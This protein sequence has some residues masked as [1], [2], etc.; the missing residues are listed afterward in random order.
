MLYC[1]LVLIE[2]VCVA[3]LST[4]NHKSNV[5]KASLIELYPRLSAYCPGAYIRF[6]LDM[7]IEMLVQCVKID[8][9]KAVSMKTIGRLC[10]SMGVHM[11]YHVHVLLA[12]VQDALL[13]DDA[14]K[15]SDGSLKKQQHKKI[16]PEALSCV[17]DMVCGLGKPFQQQVLE[18]LDYMLQSGLT[19][20]LIEALAVIA[21]NMPAHKEFIHQKL[22]GEIM[23]VLSGVSYGPRSAQSAKHSGI[24]N[25]SPDATLQEGSMA[26]FW[27]YFSSFYASDGERKDNRDHS[28]NITRRNSWS[29]RSSDEMNSKAAVPKRK[30]FGPW[31]DPETTFAEDLPRMNIMPGGV[32]NKHHSPTTV[33]DNA[34]STT[35]NSST[36]LPKVS[37]V[38][39][40]I[41]GDINDEDSPSFFK[42][43][44]ELVLLAM[45]TLQ[46]LST[47]SSGV[48]LLVHHHILP[49]LCAREEAVREEAASTAAK[50][51]APMA[52]DR[53][54]S[55]RGPSAD[56]LHMVLTRLLEVCVSDSSAQ[57]RMKVLKS[58][59]DSFDKHLLQEQRI[60]SLF[61]L[62]SDESFDIR[63]S[64]IRLIGS[65]ADK[66][67]AVVLSNMRQILKNIISQL[68]HGSVDRQK[69]EATLTLC[70]FLRETSLHVIV[71]PFMSTM[72]DVLPIDRDVRLTMAGMEALGE[73]CVVMKWHILDHVSKVM[74][75]IIMNILDGTSQR[76]QEI[77]VHTLGQLV[78]ASGLVVTPF[79]EYPQLLPIMLELLRKSSAMQ[80]SL[81][82]E[83]LRTLGL[84][85]ALNPNKYVHIE[86]HKGITTIPSQTVAV[87]YLTK[88]KRT[89]LEESYLGEQASKKVS[90]NSNIKISDLGAKN[91]M[92]RREF[93][94][95]RFKLTATEEHEPTPD[96]VGR[97]NEHTETL[98]Q[99]AVNV[100]GVEI[101]IPAHELLYELSVI[102]AKSF[103]VVEKSSTLTPTHEE[104]YPRVTLSALMKILHDTTLDMHHPAATHAITHILQTL[105]L[106]CVKYLNTVMPTFLQIIKVCAPG[107]R[108][109]LLDQLSLICE[110]AQYHLKPY[111]E[112]IFE[113]LSELW[114]D[115]IDHVLNLAEGLNQYAYDEFSPYIPRLLKLVL[116]DISN[117]QHQE[118]FTAN[119]PEAP[120][121]APLSPVPSSPSRQQNMHK[122]HATLKSMERKL[123]CLCKL[124]NVLRPH[125]DMVV[126]TLCK[127][128]SSILD[129]CESY[130][131]DKCG[132][133]IETISSGSLVDLA[134]ISNSCH[135]VS[136][137]VRTLHVLS[138]D[139]VL[140]DH[141][142]VCGIAVNTLVR[143]LKAMYTVT[144]ALPLL[145]SK[146][147]LDLF[148]DC[149]TYFCV[150]AMQLGENI[151]VLDRCIQD[152]FR[153]CNTSS[154]TYDET[155]R[156][157]I[158]GNV[159][160]VHITCPDLIIENNLLSTEY[161]HRKEEYD[162]FSMIQNAAWGRGSFMVG[163]GSQRNLLLG[164]QMMKHNVNQQQLQKV[165]NT[166]QRY[167]AA[168][169]SAWFNSVL[170]EMLRESPSPF[171]QTCSSLAQVYFPL[172][173]EL[174]Q[175]AFVSCWSELSLVYQEHIIRS[176]H[177]VFY[178]PTVPPEILLEMLNLAEFMEHDVEPLPIEPRVLA[179]LAEKSHAYAK[180]LHYREVEFESFPAISSV[181]F[182]RLIHINK[183]LNNFDG[184][185]GVLKVA[186]IFQKTRPELGIVVNEAWLAKLG[187][188]DEALDIYEKK[189]ESHPSNFDAMVGK[190]KCLNALGRWEDALDLL[191][192]NNMRHSQLSNKASHK[193]AV[194][195]AR[196]AWSLNKWD[197]MDS[198][199][200]RLSPENIEATFMS[201]VLSVHQGD[202]DK[203]ERYIDKTKMLLNQN[204]SQC[205]V[206]FIIYLLII[207]FRFF[208]NADERIV[209]RVLQPSLC[210]FCNE[211]AVE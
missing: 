99:A 139:N 129:R 81:R 154:G 31:V 168:D 182:H 63:I 66:N 160:R 32:S 13:G 72:I 112:E 96:N 119:P 49:Y 41:L 92:W 37:A 2:K 203:T 118:F 94:N 144:N 29:N 211:S 123:K 64:V 9:L 76:K 95:G 3:V 180:A 11:S 25:A 138:M 147:F 74:P 162:S 52:K 77:S 104:Y 169:W 115:H 16:P 124:K 156:A 198:F 170:V 125:I 22:L 24:R 181:C 42:Y 195:G 204:V 28:G 35:V 51:V 122:D 166:N 71:K 60:N 207:I 44:S 18:L 145:P 202:F 46:L 45:R 4:R 57:V 47:P 90:Q 142:N 107:L 201:A 68:Q 5:I 178:S 184:A 152:C 79:L 186:Q 53:A 34:S 1:L 188:W 87:D 126:S 97:K 54:L 173:R 133:G 143:S 121:Q 185:Y 75:I 114:F 120:A 20:E 208:N 199:V 132:S 15:S 176:L 55:L 108:E 190:A 86:W 109:S 43:D 19:P 73:L 7:T 130:V 8:D 177:V 27:R 78:S 23:Y 65:L 127:H 165:W 196:A 91:I 6:Y 69:E 38:T 172:A 116:A 101:D 113:V 21:D 187:R 102:Q 157:I 70:S 140:I 155:V 67:P 10:K 174:F 117:T 88:I 137:V 62:V 197:V 82:S 158:E 36:Y 26:K 209:G 134:V 40:L 85:G 131:H 192:S 128:I 39:G 171:L 89:C 150:M 103:P 59:Q 33:V 163:M 98:V 175:A 179:E 205:N 194:V 164:N 159:D 167:Q 14:E 189:L 153:Y 48:L 58:I 191:L 30:G 12:L 106:Q 61:F 56:A 151:L 135:L 206:L 136:L 84:I 93:E 148:A 200:K 80:W 105:G 110:F 50:L 83:V 141:F 183:K 100:H 111:V 193:T 149:T 146:V 210:R 161:D 17:A